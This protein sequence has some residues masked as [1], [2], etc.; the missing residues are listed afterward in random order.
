MTTT[1]RALARDDTERAPAGENGAGRGRLRPL[2]RA[3]LPIL[4]TL[5][6][7]LGIWLAVS[8]LLLTPDRREIL[9][10]P[11]QRVLTESIMQWSH[12]RPM[13][14][15]LLLDVQ[16]SMLGLLIAA[17]LG[18]L[19]AIVMSQAWWLERSIY[20]FAVLLQVVPILA[21]V[22][23][24]GLWTNY[25]W[26]GRVVVCVIIAIFPMIAN[27]LFGIHS[28]D[29]GAH[30]LFTLH[31]ATRWQRLTKLQLPAAL[32]AVF[33]GLRISSGLSVIG[34]LVGDF[35]F[36][37]G[38]PG[39][40]TLLAVYISRVQSADLFTAIL[41]S[42]LYGVVVFSAFTALG[43]VALRSWYSGAQR[44]LS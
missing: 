42:T 43:S 39:L 27:T 28:A 20:P 26:T 6:A 19:A 14:E 24:I 37:Q 10:P 30:E 3:V 35:F 16:V 36:V 11:P 29:P 9:V 15:A 1:D 4:V 31:G 21:I 44:R 18:I 40:G 8:Y 25:G 2:A 38:Q 5:I 32:P 17:V 13:L 33:T 7:F 22:P 41:L 12:L 23:L 34:A